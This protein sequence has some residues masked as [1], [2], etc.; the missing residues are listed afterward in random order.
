MMIR[1]RAAV[2]AALTAVVGAAGIGVAVGT[3][4][5]GLSFTGVPDANTKS[6]GFAR[7]NMLSPELQQVVWA[8]GSNPIENPSNGVSYYGYDD[9]APFVPVAGGTPGATTLPGNAQ[10]PG[11][12]EARKTE[13][14]KNTYLVLKGQKGADPNY[15][16]GTHFL[17]QGHEGGSPGYITRINLDAEGPHRVT[18]LA[19]QDTDGKNLPTFDGSTWDPWAKRLLFTSEAGPNSA[20]DSQGGAWQ[21]TLDV[22]SSVVSLQRFLG[23]G[24][25]EGIQND[26]NGNLYYVEDVGG[27]NLVVSGTK[28]AARRPNS[29]LYRF[30]PTDPTDLT[31]G[32]KIQALQ[33]WSKG[34]PITFAD[35]GTGPNPAAYLDLHTYNN[36]LQT[37]WV[38]LTT[39]TDATA[40]PG[41]DDNAL[42]KAAGATP[43]KRPENGLFRPGSSFKS[44]Y[45]DET[46]DTNNTTPAAATGGFTGVFKLTQDPTTND[47][48]ISLFYLGDQEHAGFDNLAWLSSSKLAFV[49]DAGDT[50]HTQRNALDSAWLFDASTD[51]S[52]PANKPIRFLAQGRDASA[53]LDSSVSALYSSPSFYNDGDNEITGFH[54]SDGDPGKS[55]ILGAKSPQLFGDE[56]GWRAFYTQQH[57]DNVTYELLRAIAR[58]GD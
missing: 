33:V 16:Y 28:T 17:F 41:P 39:T 21:A 30:L 20:G 4:G 5:P 23:R 34:S 11:Q 32:G 9:G 25:L 24:G 58:S 2:V 12:I 19:T 47:G 8:Q 55:G 46:G 57:G 45:F 27:S 6:P 56:G 18:L 54:V 40:A 26:S 15:N 52:A 14:D 10:P 50:L 53:T 31:Q 43:F 29:F 3:A 48:T 42:A 1:P 7:P 51:Y 22:P 13:P 44:F 35:G 38:T 49:E 36:P 37:K